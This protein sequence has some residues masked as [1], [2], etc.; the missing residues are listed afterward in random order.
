M[1]A[2]VSRLALAAALGAALIATPAGARAQ[3]S[4][5]VI[6]SLE[7]R[8]SAAARRVLESGLQ[9]RGLTVTL[10][11]LDPG[12]DTVA[13]RALA[14]QANAQAVLGGQASARGRG[15]WRVDLWV[16]DA[17]GG[18]QGRVRMRV[19]GRRGVARLVAAVAEALSLV[20]TATSGGATSEGATTSGGAA[21]GGAGPADAAGAPPAASA[22]GGS[23]G[24]GADPSPRPT[25]SR[26]TDDAG[27]GAEA[28][29]VRVWAMVGAGVRSRAVELLSPD[30]V[31][32]GYRAEPYFEL[33]GLVGA[34]FF[35]ILFVRG[36]FGSSVGLGS[37]R[38]AASL[39]EVDTHFFHLSGDVGASY[40]I[41]GDVELGAAIG[42]GWD[43]YE[44]SFNELVPTTEYVHLRTAIVSGFRLVERLLVLDAE[45]GLRFPFGVG[46]LQSLHGVDYSVWGVDG[47]MRLRGVVDPGFTWA[48]E[49]GFRHYQLT[50]DRAG[51]QVTGHDGG[52]HAVAY[53]GWELSL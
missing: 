52:W 40:W 3:A 25:A 30:G 10:A 46:D 51:D 29:L 27:D 24:A 48:V 41:D 18:D 35:D 11:E 26:L 43:R 1:A 6:A 2:A 5:V 13:T 28:P 47:R 21:S 4:S 50:F 8:N 7:G 9:D 17:M 53:A 16:R 37:R 49:G 14:A 42:A 44:L 32:A 39:G 34:R 45:A 20:P 31:D 38:E 36:R 12:G 15:R 22:G 19:E 33:S 23:A